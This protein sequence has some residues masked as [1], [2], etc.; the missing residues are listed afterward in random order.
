[1]LLNK[2]FYFQFYYFYFI[3]LFE[4]VFYRIFVLYF[5]RRIFFP[6]CLFV[7]F[8]VFSFYFL[9]VRVV[10]FQNMSCTQDFIYLCV[11][12]C[13]VCVL[14][15]QWYVCV[16]ICVLVCMSCQKAFV[17]CLS[18]FCFLF[19]CKDMYVRMRHVSQIFYVFFYVA[20]F[21]LIHFQ[22]GILD[23]EQCPDIFLMFVYLYMYLQ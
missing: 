21:F 10:G 7:L 23:V 22:Q 4:F 9:P 2:H 18:L 15:W 14:V 17:C 19:F 12:I 6:Y 20:I 5:P 11:C 3:L 8:Y 16:S 1:M 13:L